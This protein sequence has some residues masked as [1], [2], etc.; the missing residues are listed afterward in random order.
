MSSSFG[1]NDGGYIHRSIVNCAKE[2][3]KAQKLYS[4]GHY[5]HSNAKIIPQEH[6][7]RIIMVQLAELDK[8][9]AMYANTTP[10][11]EL[12]STYEPPIEDTKRWDKYAGEEGR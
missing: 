6:P 4:Q 11:E 10:D 9:Y 8:Q 3:K 2:L 12:F 7:F 1:P 5:S